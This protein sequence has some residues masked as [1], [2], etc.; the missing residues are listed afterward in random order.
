[1]AIQDA[2]G[3]K[4]LRERFSSDIT[5]CRHR[6]KIFSFT[7]RWLHAVGHSA[8]D[9][10]SIEMEPLAFVSF[11][12]PSLLPVIFI[13]SMHI[14]FPYLYHCGT[15]FSSH[16]APIFHCQYQH[17]CLASGTTVLTMI[18]CASNLEAPSISQYI[19]TRAIK[20]HRV[21]EAVAVRI[22]QRMISP[23]F[24]ARFQW[25]HETLRSLPIILHRKRFTADGY[26]GLTVNFTYRMLDLHC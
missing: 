21:V 6:P 9:G 17:T 24:V 16:Q 13:P 5:R 19:P 22:L 23:T 14:G 12:S 18:L 3:R 20:T 25:L 26:D 7:R 11:Q 8:E 4:T 10:L 1:M 15:A 2:L